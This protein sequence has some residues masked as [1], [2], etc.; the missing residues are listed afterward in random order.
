MYRLFYH[1]GDASLAPHLVLRELGVA[2]ELQLVDRAR[3]EQKSSE[4]LTLNPN[5]TIPTLLTEAGPLTEAAAICLYLTEQHAAG[6]LGRAA[7]F[8]RGLLYQWLIYLTNT[9]QPSLMLF[10][11]P[12]RAGA[13]EDTAIVRETAERDATA[14]F[15]RVDRFLADKPYLL[16]A[17]LSVCDLYLLMLGRWARSFRQSPRDLPHLGPLLRRLLLRPAVQRVFELEGIGAPFV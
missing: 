9:V 1:P 13:L 7:G 3:L 14:M 10:H 12:E 17:M 11:Y 5:G 16:G 4:Y 15:A 6:G 2:Y 8:E